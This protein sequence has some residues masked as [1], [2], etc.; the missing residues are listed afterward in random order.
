MVRRCPIGPRAAIHGRE[1]RRRRIPVRPWLRLEAIDADEPEP[2][3]DPDDVRPAVKDRADAIP[4]IGG[5]H[6]TGASGAGVGVEGRA[7]S[8]GAGSGGAGTGSVGRGT[9]SGGVATGGAGRASA[10]A[11]PAP[12]AAARTAARTAPALSVLP[13]S[14]FC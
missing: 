9:G 7:G 11:T 10:R 12:V 6:G 8:G 4:A 2:A 5:V 13:T 1:L 3:L 14:T